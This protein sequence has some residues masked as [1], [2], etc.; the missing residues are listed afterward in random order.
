[1]R[2]NLLSAIR[3]EKE[4]T[5]VIVLTHNIDFVFLQSVV[6]SALR[7]CGNPSLT[8]LADAGC[9]IESYG[10]QAT[11]LKHLGYRF[12]V[13]PV[14]MKEHF[15]FHPKAALL[16]GKKKA[17]LF[18]GS[19]NLTF[20]GWSNN[21]EIWVRFDTD[22]D[23]TGPFSAFKE[24]LGEVLNRLPLPEAVQDD[25]EESYDPSQKEW[26]EGLAAPSGLVGRV[27]AGPPLLEAIQG[28]VEGDRIDE[29]IVCAPYFDGGAQAL[30]QLL[31]LT[32]PRKARV[33]LQNHQTGFPKVAYGRLSKR[34]NF[35]PI[36]FHQEDKN[37][38]RRRSFVHAKFYALRTGNRVRVFSGSANCSVAALT[39][40]GQQGNAELL[41]VQEMENDEFQ[42]Q[43]LDE[44]E[45]L[46]GPPCIPEPKEE[47]EEREFLPALRVL[48]ARLEGQRLSVGFQSNEN[49]EITE[50]RI[51]GVS[52]DFELIGAE[53]V[54]AS[55]QGDARSVA[56]LGSF[57]GQ[58]VLA[59]PMWID[60]ESALATRSHHRSF[61]QA[62]RKSLNPDNW[63]L[64]AWSE[65]MEVFLRN[66]DEMPRARRRAHKPQPSE[67]K[68]TERKT[69]AFS[70][71][72]VFASGYGLEP[73]RPHLRLSS[74]E[75]AADIGQ[76]L[77][78]WFSWG[79]A[80]EH[81]AES[82]SDESPKNE[83][84]EDEDGDEP[85]DRPDELPKPKPKKRERKEKPTQKEI[86]RARRVIKRVLSR[87]EDPEYLRNRPP[88]EFSTDLKVL[89][90]LLRTAL[91]EEW[92]SEE[93]F[94]DTSERIWKSLFFSSEADDTKGWLEVRHAQAEDPEDFT[95]RM[96]STE[97]SAAMAAWAFAIPEKI[98]SAK[99]AAFRLVAVL[100][101]ARVPWLWRG[102]PEIGIAEGLEELLSYTAG[103][104]D[105]VDLAA[106]GERWLAM[107]RQGEA[108]RRL[109]RLIA[110]SSVEELKRDVTQQA[111][112]AGALL[113]QGMRGFCVAVENSTRDE[114]H[115]VSVLTLQGVVESKKFRGDFTVPVIG[116][117]TLM[118][119]NEGFGPRQVSAIKGLVKELRKGFGGL[120]PGKGN[121]HF[122]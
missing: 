105:S 81:E 74:G 117:A 41:T 36:D 115:N 104:G 17:T 86:K 99:E 97:L 3:K 110:D 75:T 90:V 101:V 8:V 85:V 16:S 57:D 109:E 31:E 84:F 60:H 80:N 26:V 35:E 77:L 89:A 42:S 95:G 106:A 78:R 7:K 34:V 116:L 63:N 67:T 48:A 66:L 52:V 92:L 5:D 13:V 96:A 23:P 22:Q 4:V 111:L 91:A 33:L 121:I 112:K 18:V 62:V 32:N 83:G 10:R 88:E 122:E 37:G 15:R 71:R 28:E 59:A 30:S 29:L 1:M 61:R 19:G 46:G 53:T 40:T 56:L 2:S 45:F 87:L 102:G 58:E 64:G 6:T 51:D 69:I 73:Q 100:S 39:S 108:L 79:D 68:D 9:A 72:D 55:V 94:F 113:W 24:Y 118:K 27:E 49:L 21:G 114:D 47:E 20:G 120:M 93:E 50:C 107:M 82:R 103:P 38:R 11:V 14:P 44:L 70:E 65:V 43:L 54:I 25:V 119:G 76:L 12:R 98:Q